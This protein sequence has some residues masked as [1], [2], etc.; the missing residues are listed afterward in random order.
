MVFDLDAAGL[1][2]DLHLGD[3]RGER[4]RGRGADGAAAVVAAE[5]GR[6]VVADRAERAELR[7][8]EL[9]GLGHGH[10]ARRDRRATQ[11]APRVTRISRGVTPSFSAT[12]STSLVAHLLRG[13]ERR[14]CRS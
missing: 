11:S 14:R 4:V 10:A 3:V 12:A 2:V 5:L 1:G 7:L 13:V 9:D 6:V 8:G